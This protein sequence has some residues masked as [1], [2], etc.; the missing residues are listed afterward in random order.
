MSY[1]PRYLED[2]VLETSRT[3]KVLYVGGPRQV[4]KTTILRHLAEKIGVNYVTLDD[5]DARELAIRDP[6]LFL[7]Q[8]RSPLFIDEVQYAP[9]IFSEIKLRVDASD[10]HGQYWLTGSEQF[11]MMKN[12][13][14]SLA[15]RVGILTLLG[16]SHAELRKQSKLSEP[17]IPLRTELSETR[18]VSVGEIFK[19]IKEGAFPARYQQNVPTLES[20][21]NSYVQTYIERDIAKLFHVS[22]LSNFEIFLQLCAARTGQLLNM[23]DLARDAGISVHAASEWLSIL[24]SGRQ[25]YLLRPYF[26]NISKRLVKTPKIYFLDTGLAAYLTRWNSAEAL[27]SG[28]MAGAFFETFVITQLIK[29]YLFRGIE[30]PIYY[31]RDKDGHEIDLLIEHSGKLTPLEIK[32]SASIT[33]ADVAPTEFWRKEIKNIENGAI[34]CATDKISTFDRY[35]QLIPCT[36]IS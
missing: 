20:F 28:A 1:I 19:E 32:L 12:V 3:F 27:R 36:L 8:Y 35:T 9:E 22:K 13:R 24:E 23:S 4:G 17:F 21:Y 30:P 7:E 34:I 2:V 5:R 29:S 11:S 33:A 26:T 18:D 6:R 25:I 16:L 15:G 31:L 14:E 10:K